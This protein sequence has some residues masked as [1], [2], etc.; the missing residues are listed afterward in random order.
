MYAIYAETIKQLVILS[1]HEAADVRVQL[2]NFNTTHY[3]EITYNI[4]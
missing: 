1:V 4:F 2:T 3:L